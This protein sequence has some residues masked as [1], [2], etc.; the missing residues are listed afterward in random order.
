MNQ[1]CV[2]NNK[3]SNTRAFYGQEYQ[4]IWQ[5][6]YVLWSLIGV[7]KKLPEDDLGQFETCRGFDGLLWKYVNFND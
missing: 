2:Q 7:K 3:L 6:I 5:P 1:F 4:Y